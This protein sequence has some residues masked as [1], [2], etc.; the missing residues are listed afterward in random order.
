MLHP[1]FGFIAPPFQ[2]SPDPGFY[3]ES[4]GHGRALS[5][6]K[7]GV[8]QREGFIVI[9]GEIGSGKTMIVRT[10]LDGLN[11]STV[12][13]AQVVN[14]QLDACGLLQA[15]CTAFGIRPQ[16]GS[17]AASLASLEA[18][19]TALA[20][21]GRRALLVV[22]EAQNLGFNELEELR[23]LSNFQLGN[24]ALLQSFLVGQPQLR[25]TLRARQTEQLRQRVLASYHLGPLSAPET[26]SYI[27]HRLHCV[28]WKDEPAIRDQAFA[29]IH[30]ASRGIPRLINVLCTRVL[31]GIWLGGRSVITALDVA[32]AASELMGEQAVAMTGRSP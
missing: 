2:L 30:A 31:L 13:A 26:R 15:I 25:E 7:Y 1:N 23:M 19:F 28:G 11:P 22:D 21:V 9:T 32:E 16:G 10:L 27:E 4:S 29:D 17:K 8:Y 18:F 20:S 6:L 3:F 5:Y 14:T 24:Q 12:A